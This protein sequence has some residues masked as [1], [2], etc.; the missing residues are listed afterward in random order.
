VNKDTTKKSNR[1]YQYIKK[2]KKISQKFNNSTANR[3]VFILK[4]RHESKYCMKVFRQEAESLHQ[5]KVQFKNFPKLC[6]WDIS[7]TY[8]QSEE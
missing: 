7:V 2:V 5:S 1:T 4:A 3:I 8:F 6:S